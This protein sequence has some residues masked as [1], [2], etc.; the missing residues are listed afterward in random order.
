MKFLRTTQSL[1]WLSLLVFVGL[2]LLWFV[3][4][5]FSGQTVPLPLL[6]ASQIPDSC[7]QILLVMTSEERAISGNLR[8]LERASPSLP[9]R[10]SGRP[11]AV[12]IGRSG[13]AWGRG[14]HSGAA[15]H[16]VRGKQEGDGCS[17]AGIYRLPFAFGYAPAAADIK[18]PYQPVTADLFGVDD[19]K[20]KYY[21]QVVNAAQVTPDWDSRE[22]M[23]REDGLYRWG[24]F[25]EHNPTRVAGA[26]SC[27][28]LHLWYGPGKPTAGCTAMSEDDLLRVLQWLEPQKEPRLLQTVEGW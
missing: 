5:R 8:L 11:I 19:V 4:H 27:I 16:G 6:F 7:H 22:T 10:Q 25:V 13:L 24:A 14:E 18:I 15:P 9:W 12:T 3:R 2:A 17:P 28:F 21:N 23:L 20:S 26:G 1:L